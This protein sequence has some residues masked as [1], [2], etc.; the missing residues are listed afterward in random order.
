MAFNASTIRLVWAGL[1]I[2]F[3]GLNAW[4]LVSVGFDGVV[5]YFTTMGPIG[6]LASVDLVLALLIGI[7]LVVRNARERSLSSRGFVLLTLLTGSLGLL[8]Y[9]ARHGT[10]DSDPAVTVHRPGSRA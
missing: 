9:L 10:A 1:L 5:T 4:A 6:L 2:G 3:A 7:V 8:G